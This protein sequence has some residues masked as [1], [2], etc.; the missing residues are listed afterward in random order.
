[1]VTTKSQRT[2]GAVALRLRSTSSALKAGAGERG[3]EATRMRSLTW[4]RA[5][6]VQDACSRAW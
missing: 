5:E 4:A 3:E 6:L 2:K 1:M